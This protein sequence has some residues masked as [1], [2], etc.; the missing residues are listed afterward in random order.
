MVICSS[1][2][3]CRRLNNRSC[4][5][6]DG[7][8]WSSVHYLSSILICKQSCRECMSSRTSMACFA[9]SAWHTIACLEIMTRMRMRYKPP[10]SSAHSSKLARSKRAQAAAAHLGSVEHT[11]LIHVIPDVQVL[12]GSLIVVQHELRGPPIPGSRV[13]VVQVSRGSR[14]TPPALQM[15]FMFLISCT[16]YHFLMS[17]IY[18]LY[19]VEEGRFT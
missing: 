10:W 15:Y 2:S 3:S 4:V 17:F 18:T 7:C 1:S 16:L 19:L 12:G 8:C 6:S 11:E 5:S 14:P 9:A 13:Q